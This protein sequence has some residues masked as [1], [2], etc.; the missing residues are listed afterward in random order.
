MAYQPALRARLFQIPPPGIDPEYASSQPL[1]LRLATECAADPGVV[2]ANGNDGNP[3]LFHTGCSVITNNIIASSADDEHLRRAGRLYRMRPEEIRRAAPEVRYLV[4]RTSDFSPEV[5]GVPR[6]LADN[7]VVAEL[8]LADEP[9]PG[10]TALHTVYF[11]TV[12]DAPD[13]IY[14]RLYKI[15]PATSN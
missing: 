7:A 15:A 2:L 13:A 1:Y 14:A 9:P 8:L 4:V 5:N 10:F 3:I 6:L 11:D 12:V